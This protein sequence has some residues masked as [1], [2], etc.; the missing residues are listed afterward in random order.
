M[1]FRS[2]SSDVFVA[3]AAALPITSI[4]FLLTQ[5]LLLSIRRTLSV[6]NSLEYLF[7]TCIFVYGIFVY[8][9]S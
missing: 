2:F 5:I 3:V 8:G 1:L 7:A 9:I 4:Y 6:D